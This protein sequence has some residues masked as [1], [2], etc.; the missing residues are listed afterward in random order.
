MPYPKDKAPSRMGRKSAATRDPNPWKTMRVNPW[1][2]TVIAFKTYCLVSSTLFISEI[3]RSALDPVYGHV[4]ASRYDGIATLIALLTAC[5]TYASWPGSSRR[6]AKWLAA[7]GLAASTIEVYLFR[8]SGRLGP[9]FGPLLTSLLTSFPLV[10]VSA[11]TA[12]K[13]VAGTMEKFLPK[14]SAQ[15]NGVSVKTISDAFITAICLIAYFE[16]K[17]G[18]S[19]LNEWLRSQLVR[20]RLGLYYL[21]IVFYA[22]LFPSG[23]LSFMIIPVL[24]PNL[25]S[26]YIPFA[27]TDQILN[28]TLHNH[29]ISLIA[30]QES[31]TGYISVLD[32]IKDG[33]RVM[34]GLGIGTTPSALIAHGIDTTVVEID[35]VVHDF[36]TQHFDL[37][38]NHTSIIQDA[39]PFVEQNEGVKKYDYIIHDV[40]TGGVEP[41]A[42]FT[43]DFLRGLKNLLKSD[44]VVA[45]VCYYFF[46]E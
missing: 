46:V 21:L 1:Q 42:L 5:S 26:A 34:S 3:L 2:I 10:L 39:V 44:G 9:S 14:G 22:L 23:Y 30:R 41:M 32:N 31:S 28:S 29:D 11:V 35:P 45:I 40:F 13:R 15:F 43:L 16:P 12:A 4:P 36:A 19:L 8:Y 38:S 37:P 7:I 33:F 25:L 24:Q 27:Y 20:S 18:S 6:W 17:I